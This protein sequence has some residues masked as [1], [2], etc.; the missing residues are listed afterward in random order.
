MRPARAASEEAQGEREA[1]GLP[2]TQQPTRESQQGCHG[3]NVP[4]AGSTF[5]QKDRRST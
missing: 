3:S 1:R 2:G 4:A 5:R